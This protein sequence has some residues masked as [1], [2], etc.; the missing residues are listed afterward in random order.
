MRIVVT[1]ASGNVGTAV[2]RSLVDDP[3]VE[4]VVGVCRRP[5]D[6]SPPRT[7]W[8]WRDV[9]EG[10]LGPVFRGAD[11]V[12]H[13][14]WLFQPTRAPA[15]TW[16][17]NV[18]GTRRVL[19]AVSES[20]VPA[21]VVASSVGA[22]S[23]RASLDPVA[24]DWPTDGAPTAAYSREKAYVERLLDLHETQHPERRVVRMRPVFIFS[25]DASIEQRRLFLGPFVPHTLL[26][27]GRIPVLPL[28]RDLVL[29]ALHTP[30]VAEAYRAAAL[31]DVRGAFNLAPDDALDPP[32]LA[33]LLHARW[34]PTPAR[35]VRAAVG[36]GF[37]LRA[38]PA[39]PEL[40]DLAM[41][42]P[43]LDAAR[44]RR[45]LG[46]TPRAGSADAVLAFLCG[47]DGRPPLPTPP[48]APRTSGPARRHELATGVGRRP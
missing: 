24:E 16:R 8:V 44:A 2:V 36:A 20:E 37:R 48:L 18:I 38:L 14:A 23:P 31:G 30:D 40:F 7:E 33:R 12:I 45:E 39:A 6:W 11:A 22:Y 26:A 4:S 46:W 43:M 27:P 17:A 1:G 29:Q 19:D 25:P 15:T 9:A 28:P 41:S 10:D 5:H 32:A 35:A 34:L 42:V 13:L 21:V 47:L 3:A